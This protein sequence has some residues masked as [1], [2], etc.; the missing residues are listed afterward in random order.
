MIQTYKIFTNKDD[1]KRETFF[2]MAEKRGDHELRRR[3]KFFKKRSRWGRRR[4]VF[5]QRVFTPG[6]MKR[7]RDTA[8]YE[9]I[10]VQ[11]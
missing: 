7:G 4:N 11:S 10:W 9:N 3:L 1:I 5:S 8:G 2:Q 6:I